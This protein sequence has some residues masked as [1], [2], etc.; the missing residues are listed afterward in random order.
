MT[1][2]TGAAEQ[3][4]CCKVGR[5]RQKYDLTTIDEDLTAKWR[6]EGTDQM[7]IRALTDEFNKRLLRA[8]LDAGDFDYL[9]GEVDNTYRMLTDDDVT[10]GVRVNIRHALKRADVAIE[11]VESDFVSHQTIYNHLTDCLD[12]SKPEKENHDPVDKV[13]SEIFSIQNRTVAV[14]DSKLEQLRN[15]DQIALDEFDVYVDVSV[16]CK[17]CQTSHDL[18]NLLRNGG[19]QCQEEDGVL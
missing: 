1:K 12:T 5:L 13:A 9:E 6:G 17:A 2:S 14:A 16:F 7:S 19:C 15:Q 10:E 18:G 4:N 3:E 8:A 11:E